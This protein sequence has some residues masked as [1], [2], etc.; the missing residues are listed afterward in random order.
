MR[1]LAKAKKVSS[2]SFKIISSHQGRFFF[3]A[4][5]IEKCPDRG[6]AR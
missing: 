2:L 4:I 1:E 3:Q 5:L 6:I